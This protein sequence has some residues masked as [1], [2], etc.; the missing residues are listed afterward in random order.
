MWSE[1]PHKGF[2]F[3]FQWKYAFVW[4]INYRQFI[5]LMTGLHSLF[6]HPP[7]AS[8]KYYLVMNTFCHRSN[9]FIYENGKWNGSWELLQQVFHCCLTFVKILRRTQFCTVFEQRSWKE[10]FFLFV[11][12]NRFIILV[13]QVNIACN[14]KSVG[15]I[16]RTVP[17]HIVY[18]MCTS[19]FGGVC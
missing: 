15:K 2:L 3:L 7:F 1:R 5:L 13:Q 9:S 16:I 18:I 4:I 8:K 14:G 10:V 19:T 12:A 11:W 17:L 6:F